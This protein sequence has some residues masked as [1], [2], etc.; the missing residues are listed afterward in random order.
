MMNRIA[1]YSCYRCGNEFPIDM[2]IDSRGCPS[3]LEIAPSNLKVLYR[4]PTP[5]TSTVKG[6]ARLPSLWRYAERLPFDESSAVSLGEG[7]TP[8]LRSERIGAVIGVPNLFIKNEG[9][10]PTWS[11]KDRFST[12]AVTAAVEAGASVVA[13][14]SSGNAGA[15]LAAYAARAGLECIVATIAGSAGPML[16]QIQKY[17]AKI[18]PFENKQ[19]RWPFLAKG[20]ERYGWFATSPYRHPVVGSHPI[21]IEGYKTLAYEIIEQFNGKVPDWCAFPVCYG[22]AI[23][24]AWLGFHEL[25]VDGLIAR[26][27]RL[28]AA[29]AHGSLATALETR[30]D[31]IPDMAASF[32]ALAVSVGATRSTY[33]ALKAL[34]ASNGTAIPVANDGLVAFQE[35]IAASEG[36]FLELSS[37]M[38]LAAIATARRRN[39]IRGDE[40]AVAVVTASGLKDIDKSISEK[41]LPR[42]SNIED[43]LRHCDI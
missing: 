14:S 30:S 20:V 25:M 18:V 34:R 5:A 22:D 11:H 10:N 29:E 33:Q 28:L 19:E 23:A 7:L 24:G 2:P 36:V 17:G 38:P 1:A 13:T 27:P 37:V 32:N 31:Q 6:I 41:P 35:R 12:V 43:A 42:F 16:S 4:A 9:Y 39:R 3:C 40:S 21:G 15:S 8:L 26:M